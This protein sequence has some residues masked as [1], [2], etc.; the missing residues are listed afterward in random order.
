LLNISYCAIIFKMVIRLKCDM[1]P[2]ILVVGSKDHDR[3]YCIDWLQPFPNIEEYDS[4]IV[5]LQSLTQDIFNQNEEK[6]LGLREPV[7]TLFQTDREVFCILNKQIWSNKKVYTSMDNYYVPSNYYWLPEILINNK[8]NGTSINVIDTRFNR[9]FE[10]VDK[11]ELE[12]DRSYSSRAMA[13]LLTRGLFPIAE[14]KSKKAISTSIKHIISF[15]GKID[16]SK[17]GAIHLLPSPTRCDIHKA[18]EILLDI[19]LG[20]EESKITPLWR[21][22]IEIPQIDLLEKTIDEKIKIIKEVQGDISQIRSQIRE[23][24]SYRDL[25]TETG[26]LLEKIVKKTLSEIGIKTKKTEKGFP[27][28]LIGEKVAVEITGIKGMIGVS[29]SKV[30]QA[31]RLRECYKE[32]EKIILIAN[33]YMDIPPKER[34]GNLDF[35]LE[36]LEYFKTISVSCLTSFTLFQLWKDI[37]TGKKK[38]EN[39]VRKLIIK[40]GE[41]KFDDFKSTT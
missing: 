23:W 3:A 19:V 7:D 18:I 5:N 33:T 35:S 11:W 1:Q 37:I 32:Y 29:S 22:N 30:I 4:V 38:R 12:I 13:Y 21:N 2:K 36:V 41:L 39:V 16:P 17:K 34:E 24:D 15:S 6:I 40:T 20:R 25:L 28:D 10:C 8:R 27:A 14:N 9:Y 31:G 26:D